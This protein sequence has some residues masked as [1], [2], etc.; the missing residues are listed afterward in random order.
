MKKTF[1][2]GPNHQHFST[3]A[4]KQDTAHSEVTNAPQIH[5]GIHDPSGEFISPRLLL[6]PRTPPR[7]LAIVQLQSSSYDAAEVRT[8]GI[9]HNLIRYSA[10]ASD[11]TPGPDPAKTLISLPVIFLYRMVH[12]GAIN[13]CGHAIVMVA[14]PVQYSPSFP[15]SPLVAAIGALVV[16]SIIILG[17]FCSA[18][19]DEEDSAFDLCYPEIPR[20]TTLYG[21]HLVVDRIVENF[22][23]AYLLS[24]WIPGLHYHYIKLGIVGCILQ[25]LFAYLAENFSQHGFFTRFGLEMS[26]SALVVFCGHCA[27]TIVAPLILVDPADYGASLAFSPLVGALGGVLLF[28]TIRFAA[29]IGFKNDHQ[30]TSESLTSISISLLIEVTTAAA[31]GVVVAVVGVSILTL[32][33]C[34]FNVLDL[35]NAACVGATGGAIMGFIGIRL[36]VA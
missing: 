11:I 23:G 21:L 27:F 31:L 3:F 6:N 4:K 19:L 1:T 18:M 12:S 14:L 36:V 29:S 16:A 17:Y 34:G 20:T 26:K 15:V 30:E 24:L 8:R 9:L 7:K 32:S 2:A 33:R 28:C 13:M 10:T 35:K 25:N 22:V 5:G